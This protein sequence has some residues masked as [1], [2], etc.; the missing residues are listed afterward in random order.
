M[1][2]F[3]HLEYREDSLG[4]ELKVSRAPVLLIMRQGFSQGISVG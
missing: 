2:I 4:F 3:A 1:V